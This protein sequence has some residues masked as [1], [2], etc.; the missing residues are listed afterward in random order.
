MRSV[1]HKAYQQIKSS[2]SVK[3]FKSNRNDYKDGEQ[4][5]DFVYVKDCCDLISW[6]VKEKNVNGI[7]NVGS[8]N[9]NSW[10]ELTNGVFKALG[11]APKIEYIEMP[12]ELAAHY[13]YFTQAD[14][15][16]LRAHGYDKPF[17]TLEDGV[18]DYV[19]NYLETKC[20]YL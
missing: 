2:G 4:K 11:L 10:N 9:A 1:A 5:R 19:C 17:H 7:F 12:Q 16:K 18:R 14:I 8:G 6:F 3:L 15:S 20:A 13:Q